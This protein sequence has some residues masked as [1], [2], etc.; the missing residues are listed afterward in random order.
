MMFSSLSA[1]PPLFS[2]FLPLLGVVVGLFLSTTVHGQSTAPTFSQVFVFGDSLSDTGNVANETNNR[3]ATRY[4]GDSYNYDGGRFTNGGSTNPG[5]STYL[6]VWHEQ[7]ERAL[8]NPPLARATPSRDGGTNYAFGGATT[9]SGTKDVTVIS[10]PE[11]FSGGQLTITIDNL[12]RQIDNFLSR[13]TAPDSAALYVVWAGGNDLFNDRS[14]A[15]VTATAGRLTTQVERL[16]RAGAKNVIVPNVPP[17]GSI[18]NY[19]GQPQKAAEL[20]AASASY[21]DQLNSNL[22]TLQARLATDGIP[23]SL[24]RLDV[25]NLFLQLVATPSTYGFTNVTQSAQGQPVPVNNY[26]FWDSIHP[27]TAGHRQI[28]IAAYELLTHPAFF[29]GEVSLGSGVYYLQLAASGNPFGFYAYLSDNRYIFHYDLGYEYLFDA[30][31]SQS[32]LYLYDFTSGS[33][34]YTS[35]TFPFP[36]L[37]DFSLKAVLYYFPNPQQPGR[38]TSGPRYFYNFAT[39]TVITK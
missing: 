15:N 19:S 37:Y 36:Y 6:G 5:N 2:R 23:F 34:F 14:A 1:K 35:R 26:L 32:G 39:G 33:F 28:A 12:G 38:Y 30:N 20:N 16:V 21:R 10:S 24:Y 27:T 9:E 22:D 29:N 31:D 3:F 7:L 11:P 8:F 4:P 25:Y 17:L 13:G 18:P